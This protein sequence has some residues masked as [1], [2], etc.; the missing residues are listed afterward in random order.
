MNYRH[1][2][3]AGNFADVFKHALLS[4]ILVYLGRKPTPFRY[5]DT[6]AGLGRY[7][8]AGD[9]A[10]R[11]GE[12]RAGIGR[13]CAAKHPPAIEAL[14]RPYLDAV[15]FLTDDG[16]PL[17][18]PGSPALAQALLR[19]GDRLLLAELHPDDAAALRVAIGRDKRVKILMR[20]GYEVLN[21]AIPPPE[22]RG[23]ILI[24]PPFEVPDEF[25][26][27]AA[28]LAGACRKW[29]TGTYAVWYPIKDAAPLAAF[30]NRLEA[31]NL[32][33]SCRLEFAREAPAPGGALRGCGLFVINP[34]Y[35][36]ADEAR[37]LLPYLAQVLGQADEPPFRPIVA[38]VPASDRR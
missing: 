17:D 31:S 8:L 25:D 34:P 23:L 38:E 3:H 1:A 6:H 29:A 33:P 2:F 7:D 19:E 9:E 24:D 13:L 32:P 12:W 4:R 35:L 16:R 15:G 22:R 14:L 30:Y 11:T 27:L 36:L 26:R 5:I 10:T 18:Y 20:D 28:A 37:Q 21:A